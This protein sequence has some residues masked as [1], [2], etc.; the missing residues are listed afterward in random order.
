M[1]SLSED[2]LRWY[3]SC[4]RMLPWREEPGPY[5]TWISE[6]MLQQTRVSTV[7]PYFARFMEALPTVEDLADASLEQV[8]YLWAGLGYYSRARNL[9]KAAQRIVE[10]GE[11]PD[12]VESLRELPGVGP[13]MAGAIA[14]IAFGQ[15]VPTV[16]GNIR[17][18][19]SRVHREARGGAV[20]WE[21]A[22][23]HI[24]KGRA[25]DHNQALMDLGA[26]ICTPRSPVCGECPI[27]D[28]CEALQVGDI[29]DFPP[30]KVR[31]QSPTW[32][33]ACAIARGDQGVL[34]GRRA[35]EGLFG[36][37]YEPPM[38]RV[39]SGDAEVA[40]RQGLEGM[41]LVVNQARSSGQVRHELTHRILE[42][43]RYEVAV[44]GSVL[45]GAYAAADW[46][47]EEQL[48]SLGLSTLARKALA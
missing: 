9:H 11:F 38:F 41:G 42:V 7:L 32:T 19:L 33:L 30:P 28:Y 26:R 22:A 4:R 14:S 36:G 29:E 10:R 3:D 37:L 16:D 45:P 34:L 44:A 39:E 2:L 15:D 13:Y 43:H 27:S 24:P 35:P 21:L 25:G 40:L 17:R 48:S 5:R 23:R 46:V 6:A 47:S 20:T 8:L 1:P 18:V 12:T 31:R